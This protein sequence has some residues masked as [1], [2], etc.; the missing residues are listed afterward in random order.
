MKGCSALRSS[1]W[2]GAF[3][4]ALEG[5]LFLQVRNFINKN[6][7]RYVRGQ[8]GTVWLQMHAKPGERFSVWYDQAILVREQ[9]VLLLLGFVPAKKVAAFEPWFWL[10]MYATSTKVWSDGAFQK[11]KF[12]KWVRKRDIG[13]CMLNLQKQSAYSH[14]SAWK[15]AL[16]WKYALL[17]KYALWWKQAL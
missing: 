5:L 15:Y 2:S 10:Y 6:R 3:H 11:Y 12:W 14:R 9:K 8:N 7:H 4:V 16:W 1:F 17:W 13:L